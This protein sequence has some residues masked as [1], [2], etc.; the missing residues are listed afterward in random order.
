MSRKSKG[1]DNTGQAPA[2]PPDPS[3]APAQA[4]EESP[5]AVNDAT[6][7]PTDSTPTESQL[8][9]I[10]PDQFAAMTGS[11]K[12]TTIDLMKKVGWSIDDIGDQFGIDPTQAGDL[13]NFWSKSDSEK[14]TTLRQLLYA[15]GYLPQAVADYL[16]IS[17]ADQESLVNP[18]NIKPD[19]PPPDIRHGHAMSV[20]EQ[21]E[22]GTL[23]TV[24]ISASMELVVT[25]TERKI[26]A[27]MLQM[28]QEAS[29]H[30]GKVFQCYRA[31]G[32]GMDLLNKETGLEGYR[33]YDRYRELSKSKTG[34]KQLSRYMRLVP[35]K[36]WKKICDAFNSPLL[37]GVTPT[38]LLVEKIL[39]PGDDLGQQIEE[40]RK[41]A[42]EARH[43]ALGRKRP[44]AEEMERDLLNLTTAL[45]K[46]EA[47]LGRQVHQEPKD[48]DK[49]EK[50][51]EDGD[52]K[53][54]DAK[55][56]DKDGEDKTDDDK[57]IEVFADNLKTHLPKRVVVV[58][59]AGIKPSDGEC[60]IHF[61]GKNGESQRYSAKPNEVIILRLPS[62]Q[63]P[64]IQ[65]EATDEATEEFGKAVDE[66]ELSN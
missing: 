12:G 10:T 57:A 13:H 50:E 5:P 3:P 62:T 36:N 41:A 23:Q 48:E 38:W 60:L 7:S 9:A 64:N 55:D 45:D 16:G 46:E 33:L 6:P 2:P 37:K 11:E 28:E 18:R 56:E 4:Q 65:E 39:K 32:L 17:E 47:V 14:E 43:K 52:G 20:S 53:E 61:T 27:W 19:I 40:A 54:E 22:G 30:E 44:P 35:E 63:E 8:K 26:A 24:P 49:E 31:V 1:Q 42:Q 34:D 51:D 29:Y 59:E 58:L 21:Q 15:K 25:P 66:E